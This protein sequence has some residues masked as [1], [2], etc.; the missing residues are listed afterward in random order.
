MTGDTNAIEALIR[1]VGTADRLADTPFSALFHEARTTSRR[2]YSSVTVRV[3]VEDGEVTV[4]D[5]VKTE[6]GQHYRP[7][8]GQPIHLR[9]QPFMDT[10]TARQ[11]I[12]RQLRIRYQRVSGGA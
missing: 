5:P 4:G 2:I 8:E 11:E 1:E 9:I 12:I 3:H 7:H 10:R 6:P